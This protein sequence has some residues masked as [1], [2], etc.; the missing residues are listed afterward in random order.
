MKQSR[1]SK[2]RELIYDTL[3]HTD[4]H[5]SAEMIYQSLR[6]L[7]PSLSLGTVYR[8]LNFLVSEGRVALI[9]SKVGRYDAITQ[10]HPHFCCTACDKVYDL[11]GSLDAPLHAQ[12]ESLGHQISQYDIIVQGVCADCLAKAKKEKTNLN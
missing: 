11:D 9:P 5:P 8:N 10:T 7:A 1:Y 2:Q 12:V 6:E 3:C 4:A